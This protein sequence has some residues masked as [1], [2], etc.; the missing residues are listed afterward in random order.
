MEASRSPGRVTGA[1]VARRAGVSKA[2]VSQVFGG[3]GRISAETARRVQEAAAELG[4]APDHAARSLRLRRTGMLTMIIPQVDN[5]YYLEI[6]AAGQAAAAVRGYGLDLFAAADAAAARAK[7]RQVGTGI[8]DGVV[9][10]GESGF[11]DG[12]TDELLRLRE[13]GVAV[14]VTHAAGPDPRIPGVRVDV[15]HGAHLAVRHLVDLGHRRIAYVGNRADAAARARDSE[16]GGDGRWRGYREAL[17]L[18]GIDYDEALVHS[19][20]PTA[21]GGATCA[22]A[23]TAGPGPSPTA[24]FA[25]NDL[26][27]MGILHGLAM[28]GV[29]VPAE[30]SVVGF[31]GIE[32]AEFTVPALTTIAH[33][34]AE[35]GRQAVTRLCDQLDGHPAAAPDFVLTP[36]LV[37]RGST[38]ACG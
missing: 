26:V 31:D 21:R 1:D 15:E 18:A 19:A 4:Y 3:T 12:L 29:S 33:P 17:A 35:L 24:V 16:Y 22:A 30:M 2:A 36:S 9:L 28:A 13:R 10:C 34:R 6:F 8:S 11:D 14:A 20:D 38:G 23:L 37:V 25:F 27:G 7:L 5:P 32:L